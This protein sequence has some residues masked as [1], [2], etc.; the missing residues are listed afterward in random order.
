MGGS[1]RRICNFVRCDVLRNSETAREDL[2]RQTFHRAPGAVDLRNPRDFGREPNAATAQKIA[3]KT[4]IE[5][6]LAT[7][8]RDKDRRS[9]PISRPLHVSFGPPRRLAGGLLLRFPRAAGLVLQ[10]HWGPIGRTSP[11]KAHLI[12]QMEIT[13]PAIGT[14]PR[15][16]VS[17]LDRSPL[18]Q[19]ET[20]CA[21]SFPNRYRAGVNRMIHN[22]TDLDHAPSRARSTVYRP[23]SGPR[24][25]LGQ[26]SK[27]PH[28][29]RLGAS[30]RKCSVRS[31]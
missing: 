28:L 1:T 2:H 7:R 30:T 29:F 16:R 14:I 8:E 21:G 26:A 27:V 13:I 3:Q 24:P 20:S 10:L 12:M 15:H 4:K 22:V 9:G 31:S 25:D 11:G 17:S 5:I 18:E 19:R 6:G 23:Q